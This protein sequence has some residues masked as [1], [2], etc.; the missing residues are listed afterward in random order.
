MDYPAQFDMAWLALDRTGALAAMITGGAGPIP[1]SVLAN[2]PGDVLGIEGALLELPQIAEA[3][4]HDRTGDPSSFIALSERGLFVYDWSDVHRTSAEAL[5][6]YE[7][8]SSPSVLLRATDLPA[9]LRALAAPIGGHAF[10]ERLL[11]IA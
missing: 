5:G 6:A 9:A 1:A 10:G 3:S 4:V 2:T 7:L 8:M 11:K